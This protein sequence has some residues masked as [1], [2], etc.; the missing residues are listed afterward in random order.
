MSSYHE[1]LHPSVPPLVPNRNEIWETLCPRR[2][3]SSYFPEVSQSFVLTK[4]GDRNGFD[5]D[6]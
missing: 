1:F 2:E 3:A 6:V 4:Q 5:F